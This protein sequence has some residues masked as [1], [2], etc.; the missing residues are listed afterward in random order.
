[1]KNTRYC[2]LSRMQLL[3]NC[4]SVL[5][6]YTVHYLSP[7]TER[8]IINRLFVVSVAICFVICP[9]NFSLGFEQSCV[10]WSTGHTLTI[11][12]ERF[13]NNVAVIWYCH[14]CNAFEHRSTF[15]AI[16]NWNTHNEFTQPNIS[17]CGSHI[18]KLL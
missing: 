12:Y 5:L 13:R 4:T 18:K 2:F 7:T 9:F 10:T 17:L 16:L 3:C 6:V 11:V 1:M 8:L 14:M 15:T